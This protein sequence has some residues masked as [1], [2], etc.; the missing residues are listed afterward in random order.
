[1]TYALFTLMTFQNWTGN[2]LWNAYYPTTF[3]M[4]AA[5]SIPPGL[6][7]YEWEIDAN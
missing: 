6:D 1:M 3:R 4:R 5:G 2:P 7:V